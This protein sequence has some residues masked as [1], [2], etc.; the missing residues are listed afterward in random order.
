MPKVTLYNTSGEQV[1]ELELNDDVFGVP[2]HHQVMHDAV[3][4]HLARRRRGTHATKTRAEVRGG[5][6][7]PW[8]QKGT[9]RARHGTRRSP[10]WV[11]GGIVFGPHPRDYSYKLPKKMRR[12]AMKSALSSKCEDGDIMVLDS[13]LLNEPKTREMVNILNNLNINSKALVVT[14][15]A[16]Q[17]VYKSTR[18]IPGIKSVPAQSLNVYD[19]LAHKTLLITKGAVSAVEEVLTK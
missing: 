12:L 13:L 2:V 10:I 17:N 7:R 16:D 8:R 5:G 1:G 14:A 9:G 6:R 4:C 18:N 3:V 19:I 15:G 11:G